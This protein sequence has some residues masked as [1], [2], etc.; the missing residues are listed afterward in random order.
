MRKTSLRITITV[1]S[2]G[3]LS[4]LIEWI[5]SNPSRG[6]TLARVPSAGDNCGIN[7]ILVQGLIKH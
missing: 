5:S 2:N 3:A 1:H 6:V 4:V 7:N